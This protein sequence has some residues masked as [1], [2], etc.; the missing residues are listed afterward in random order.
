[1]EDLPPRA[2]DLV[3]DVQLSPLEID[4]LP[5]ETQGDVGAAAE[6]L[7]GPDVELGAPAE[8]AGGLVFGGGT[9]TEV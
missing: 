6:G 8:R 4:G 3:I 1:V 5:S 7:H 2:L 9:E